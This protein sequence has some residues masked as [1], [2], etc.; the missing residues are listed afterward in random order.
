MRMLVNFVIAAA[1]GLGIPACSR[2]AESKSSAKV[3][4]NKIDACMLLT[5]Q[6]IE[7]VQ[8]ASITDTKSS[9]T[10]G[11]D[12]RVS[13]CFYTAAEFNKSLSLAVIQ[14]DLSETHARTPK[15]FWQ[16]TFTRA[17]EKKEGGES[18]AGEEKE[19]RRPPKKIDGVGDDAY[20]APNRFGGVLYVLKGDAFIS[21]SVGGP[22]NEQVKIEKSKTLAQK[23]ISRLWLRDR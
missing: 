14:K 7:I 16:Q 13:Q 5:R 18:E 10:A 2:R 12:F 19:P 9:N 11:G 3:A 21:I 17:S 23:A 20:W 6:E 4:Q 1:V 22:D 15:Q 8:G